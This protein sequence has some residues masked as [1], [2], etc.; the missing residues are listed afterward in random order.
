[1]T[2]KSLVKCIILISVVS[3]FQVL[4]RI[5]RL[6]ITR[7][8]FF[9]ERDGRVGDSFIVNNNKIILSP[10]FLIDFE[11]FIT[12]GHSRERGETISLQMRL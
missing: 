6:R 2:L 12:T 8:I 1:M 7:K 4:F 9:M 3:F 11:K 10:M 5:L